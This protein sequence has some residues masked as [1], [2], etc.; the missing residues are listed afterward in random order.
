MSIGYKVYILCRTN[1]IWTVVVFLTYIYTHMYTW[2]LVPLPLV[3][4]RL[5]AIV[6]VE[7][8]ALGWQPPGVHLYLLSTWHFSRS[9]NHFLP[10]YFG[11][12]F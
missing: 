5:S 1:N 7:N 9:S 11:Q 3:P 10:F 4:Y 8:I 2:P 6:H 12:P